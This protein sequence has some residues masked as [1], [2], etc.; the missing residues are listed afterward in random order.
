M[1]GVR[2]HTTEIQAKAQKVST[3]L[4]SKNGLNFCHLNS[5]LPTLEAGYEK[6]A[7][8]SKQAQQ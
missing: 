4:T 2:S 1:C 3:L 5:I 7:T 6:T 8:D